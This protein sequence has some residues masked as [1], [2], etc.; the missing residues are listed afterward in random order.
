MKSAVLVTDVQAKV[1]DTEPRPFEA[2]EVVKRINHV[3]EQS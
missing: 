3:T 2:D 1:F